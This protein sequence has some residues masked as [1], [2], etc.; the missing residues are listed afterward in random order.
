MT[1]IT[2]LEV[3]SEVKRKPVLVTAIITLCAC[4]YVALLHRTGDATDSYMTLYTST[5][6]HSRPTYISATQTTKELPSEPNYDDDDVIID[7]P[8]QTGTNMP[9]VPGVPTRPTVTGDWSE[10]LSARQCDYYTNPKYLN[11]VSRN[12]REYLCEFQNG[13][14]YRDVPNTGNSIRSVGCL[15]YALQA[16][17]TNATGQLYSIEDQINVDGPVCSW[18]G[19]RWSSTSFPYIVNGNTYVGTYSGTVCSIEGRLNKLNSAYGTTFSTSSDM[20][21]ASPQD[22]TDALV[23]GKWV[24]VHV[25]NDTGNLYSSGGQHWFVIADVNNTGTWYTLQCK[26]NEITPDKQQGMLNLSNHVYFI[27]K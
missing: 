4:L 15:M 18:D 11:V 14:A 12:G 22:I 10:Q 21:S 8:G 25:N 26:A 1:Q 17:T 7:E 5:I 19:S 20:P 2:F 6:N 27:T 13:D 9:G 24:L 16:I 23:N 3:L